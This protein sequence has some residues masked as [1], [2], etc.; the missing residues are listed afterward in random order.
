MIGSPSLRDNSC[1]WGCEHRL[2][3]GEML[4]APEQLAVEDETRHSEN[5][6]RLGHAADAL[7]LLSTVVRQI[8]R[9]ARGVGAGLGQHGAH[10]GGIFDVELAFPEALED[11]VVIPAQ[12]RIAP[13]F[14]VEH[15]A[16]R[17]GRVPN[18]LRAADNEAALS[19]LPAAVHVAVA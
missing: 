2:D 9:E 7:D 12:H 4:A 11:H 14:G 1:S 5:T 15:A 8:S 19:G 3:I 17:E 10:N 13:P 6:N 18:F 16:C